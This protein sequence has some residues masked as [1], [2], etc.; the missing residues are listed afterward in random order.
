[1][2]ECGITGRSYTYET[3]RQ[4]IKRYGSALTRMGFKKGEVM[5]IISPNVPEYPIA[6]LGASGAG[7]PVA[8]I[9]PTHTPGLGVEN[10]K[11][12]C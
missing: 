2:Q 6:L 4:L 8:L 10:Y 9:N 1:M 11:F 7:M 12:E 5:A 3:M